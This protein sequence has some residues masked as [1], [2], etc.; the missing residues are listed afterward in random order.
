MVN[1]YYPYV[2]E[3]VNKSAVLEFAWA[4]NSKMQSLSTP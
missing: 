2:Y 4:S 3:D 1:S